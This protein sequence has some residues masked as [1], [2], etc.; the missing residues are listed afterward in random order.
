MPQQPGP[1]APEMQPAA[2]AARP[3]SAEFLQSMAA[4]LAEVK[5]P[6]ERK[7]IVAETAD[8][9]VRSLRPA[10]SGAALDP[11]GK[12]TVEA[13]EA[14]AKTLGTRR[15]AEGTLNTYLFPR[16][17]EGGSGV[18]FARDSA[19]GELMTLL[20]IPKR[21]QDKEGKPTRPDGWEFPAGY[22]EALPEAK[23]VP[24]QPDPNAPVPNMKEPTPENL[25]SMFDA[26]LTE[27]LKTKQPGEIA[28]ILADPKQVRAMFD[29]HGV[30]WSA[31][32]D[33]T[34][35]DT[36]AREVREE[37][38][39]EISA[40][41]IRLARVEST[42][43]FASGGDRN[44]HS[45]YVYAADLGT[46]EKLP[47]ITK[48]ASE[49]AEARWVRVKDIARDAA[50]GA[51]VIAGAPEGQ[52]RIRKEQIH[53]FELALQTYAGM[54]IE[55]AS[56]VDLGEGRAV[57]EFDS[58][59]DVISQLRIKAAKE[60]A[61][62]TDELSAALAAADPKGN[63]LPLAGEEGQKRLDALLK[64]AKG[65]AGD[66]PLKDIFPPKE[67]EQPK[68]EGQSYAPFEQGAPNSLPDLRFAVQKAS[69]I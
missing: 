47:A 58:A 63:L 35:Q 36:F 50:T 11:A 46:L 49:V 41:D 34:P 12:S 1:A 10:F 13:G 54:Q 24:A 38:G 21:N 65:L 3:L 48:Q 16:G 6:A 33:V 40:A 7:R 42:V 68:P 15:R 55:K 29:K 18:V 56:V 26:E 69:L 27:M 64:A 22:R 57:S 31:E 52:N 23:L 43:N 19:T 61:P 62:L 66:A 53:Q 32:F 4:Q 8:E 37:T 39:V 25:R 45:T 51:Y 67:G 14:L 59:R 17:S 30:R 9:L 28:A 44:N 5:D 20:E 60:K 2:Q